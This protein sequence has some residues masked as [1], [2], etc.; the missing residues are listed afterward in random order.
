MP[1]TTP[2]PIHIGPH[3]YEV[4]CDPDTASLLRD[5]HSRGDSRPDQLL[6]RLDTE[7]PHT[8]V[9]ETLLHEA[10]HCVWHQTPLRT[11]G[12]LDDYEEAIVTALAPVLLGLL[13][14]NPDLVGY[15]TG[16]EG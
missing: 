16:D 9:A 14:H 8:A 15:L 4:R 1:V 5:E 7:R 12:T 2:S 11:D 10:L 13:R 3:A 6:I